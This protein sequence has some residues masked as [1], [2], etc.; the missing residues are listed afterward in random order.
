[1]FSSLLFI[2]TCSSQALRRWSSN[3]QPLGRLTRSQPKA[4]AHTLMDRRHVPFSE[5]DE[6][7]SFQPFYPDRW[8]G[9]AFCSQLCPWQSCPHRCKW[10]QKV[11]LFLLNKSNMVHG[12]GETA[13]QARR[14]SVKGEVGCGELK[15][16]GGGDTPAGLPAAPLCHHSR[17]GPV[18]PVRREPALPG[19]SRSS[20]GKPAGSG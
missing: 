15:V 9:H 2:S 20:S 1:M 4:T 17:R 12:E 14:I 16:R 8:R 13:G 11:G 3:A 6:H 5:D 18:P 7:P 19:S 10:H